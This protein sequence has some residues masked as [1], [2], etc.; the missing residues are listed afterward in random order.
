MPYQTYKTFSRAVHIDKALQIFRKI[1]IQT[2]RLARYCILIVAYMLSNKYVLRRFCYKLDEECF[3]IFIIIILED[4]IWS[5]G[6]WE[7]LTCIIMKT[8]VAKNV[9][10][11]LECILSTNW[12]LFCRSGCIHSVVIKNI[13]ASNWKFFNLI[14]H[15][16][17]YTV[18]CVWFV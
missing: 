18:L 5:R 3:H 17:T 12:S 13:N 1:K 16:Y 2:I 4:V 9:Q 6:T 7:V 8:Y 15:S 14:G 10:M 11:F